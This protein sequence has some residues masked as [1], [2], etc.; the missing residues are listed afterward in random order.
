[1]SV[2]ACSAKSFASYRSPRQTVRTRFKLSRF[3]FAFSFGGVAR[4]RASTRTKSYRSC[5][6]RGP[7]QCTLS[8][9]QPP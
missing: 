3:D 7:A 9:G 2:R 1:M 4:G 5:T 6:L 8:T